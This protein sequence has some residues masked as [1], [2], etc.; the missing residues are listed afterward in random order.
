MNLFKK[1]RKVLGVCCLIIIVLIAVLFSLRNNLLHSKLTAV[2]EKYKKDYNADLSIEEASFEGI[3][4]III[5]RIILIPEH[6]DTVL[7]I[8]SVSCKL[9]L[10][11]L[12]FGKIR[13]NYLS[14]SNANINLIK[15]KNIANYSFLFRKK[16]EDTLNKKEL[17]YAGK[18]DE[19]YT[20]IFNAI[21]GTLNLDHFSLKVR[22]DKD[23][24]VLNIPGLI[25]KDGEIAA[26]TIQLKE[27]KKTIYC[28]L[29]GTIHHNKRTI[30]IALNAKDSIKIHLEFLEK[31]K[32]LKLAFNA[33]NFEINT[34]NYSSNETKVGGKLAID[35]LLLNHPK[36]TTMDATIKNFAIDFNFNAG[37][38]EL[39]IDSSSA[40]Q[41][42]SILIHSYFNLINHRENKELNL[43]IRIPEMEAAKFFS[44]L[45]NGM[46]DNTNQI[47]AKGTVSYNLDFYI[48]TKEP[49]SLKFHS[50]FDAINFKII[51]FGKT[52]F[53]KINEPFEYTAY[54]YGIPQQTFIV[55]PEN[56]FFTPL[57][58]ISPYLKNAILN[59][60]DGIF[61]YHKGFIESAFAQ[62]IAANIKT[63]QF[64]RGGST[65]TMQ[66]VKNVFLSKNKTIGRKVEEALIVWLIENNNLSSKDR[67]Y[68]VY[69][70]II[71]WGPNIYGN[72][73]ASKFYFNKRPS[74]LSLSESIFLASIIPSPKWFKYAFDE[75]GKLKEERLANFKVLT[76]IL[77]KIGII[78]EEQH[79]SFIP[80]VQLKGK[81]KLFLLPKDSIPKDSLL[82]NEEGFDY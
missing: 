54:S 3:N 12:L 78:T 70:N 73:Q 14:V 13:L 43:K 48:D 47:K 31:W 49:D 38:D 65:L 52:N 22:R 23:K 34:F 40:I 53:T 26:D 1:Y 56:P 7:A 10:F 64:T 81:A 42:N 71:E 67:M 63:G 20:K 19:L 36:L 60:E 45:P 57:N 21:P 80:D 69:L 25:I 51:Q 15:D 59:S 9:N 66:L 77:F 17:D 37:K 18:I 82:I 24:F 2:E 76:E 61:Y 58:E 35:G 30:T 5:K 6:G 72:A 79:D 50:S 44:S 46:F 62:S 33:L 55:G 4:E 28:M 68:E 11:K 29:N 39:N 8:D 41:V 74:D 27:G 16:D 75:S 32:Q